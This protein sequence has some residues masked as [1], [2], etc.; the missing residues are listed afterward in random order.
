MSGGW[1]LWLVALAAAG[2]LLVQMIVR[3][4]LVV[5][6]CV[7]A[8]LLAAVLR[9][10]A[11]WLARRMPRLAATWLVLLAGLLV[12]GALGWL[13]GRGAAAEF[14]ALADRLVETVRQARDGLVR[15]GGPAGQLATADDQALEALRRQLNQLGGVPGV[16]GRIIEFFAGAVLALFITF[17]LVK[18]GDRIWRWLVDRLPERMRERAGRAGGASWTVLRHY[19]QGTLVIASIHAVVLGVAMLILGVPL[20][21]PLAVLIFFGSFIPFIGSLIAGSLAV[22][23]ALGARGLVVGLI[24]LAV[25]LVENQL[26]EHVLEPWVMGSYVRIHP[27][28]IGLALAS[29]TILGGVSGALV[30]VP[31]TAIAY[32]GGRELL[33]SRPAGGPGSSDG[34]GPPAQAQAVSSEK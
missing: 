28:V 9:P 31:L 21:L 24:L 33:R 7:V 11:M 16:A 27:L 5:L 2:Y 4:R 8:L 22:V 18:D 30:S 13:I 34:S 19:I 6:A 23:V 20:A 32:Y 12:I 10:P 17:F 29:G 1:A 25:L 26:E 15:L 3:L 14:P